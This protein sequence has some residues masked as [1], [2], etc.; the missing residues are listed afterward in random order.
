VRG[1][2]ERHP[3]YRTN[4]DYLGVVWAVGPDQRAVDQA[5]AE[6]IAANRWEITA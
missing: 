1:I 6:F 5:V 4:R 2:G 3:H